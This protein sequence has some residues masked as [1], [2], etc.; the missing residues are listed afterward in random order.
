M[1]A[2]LTNSDGMWARANRTLNCEGMYKR[3]TNSRGNSASDAQ[4]QVP[5][6]AACKGKQ[7]VTRVGDYVSFSLTGPD[8]CSSVSLKFLV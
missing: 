1:R 8:Y 5:A 3:L 2:H 6:N 4:T 7:Y